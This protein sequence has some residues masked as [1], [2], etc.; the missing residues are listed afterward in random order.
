MRNHSPHQQM[1]EK[2]TRI[3]FRGS[4]GAMI[5]GTACAISPS[6]KVMVFQNF[7]ESFFGID[8]KAFDTRQQRAKSKWKIW[9]MR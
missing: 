4:E 2:E 9:S 3:R 8:V 1:K 6:I 7:G 5:S